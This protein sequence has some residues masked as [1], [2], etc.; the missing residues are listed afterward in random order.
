MSE[1]IKVSDT[2]PDD[3]K[4]VLVYAKKQGAEPSP[5][6]IARQY[7]GIWE[8][9]STESQSNAFACG[10]LSWAMDAEEIIH[11]LAIPIPGDIS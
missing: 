4:Y 3:Y 9:L 1:W 6:S 5:I 10:D 7:K 8:M 2:L 11:W